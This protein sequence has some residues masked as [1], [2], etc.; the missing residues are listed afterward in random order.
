MW[1]NW[2]Q[3][4]LFLQRPHNK[5]MVDKKFDFLDKVRKLNRPTKGQFAW[6]ALGLAAALALFFFSRGFV[7]CWRLTALGG[8]SPSSCPGQMTVPLTTTN[9]AGTAVTIGTGV[10]AF[11]GPQVALPPPWDGASRV[12]I[13]IV[14]LDFGDW[15]ADRNGPSRSDTMI[16]LTIDPASKTAGMLSVPRDM[17]VNI[18]G[19]GYSKINNAYAFGEGYKLPGG[20][21]GLA[22]KTVENFLGINIQYYA[23]V[24]FTTFEKMVDTIGGVCLTIPEEI[25]V[26][27]TFEHSVTLKPGYQCL[28]GKSTLGYARNRY[29]TNG[30]VDRAGRQQQVI[31]AI[32]DK[33]FQPA[34]FL[35]LISQ[36]PTLYN[37]LS[38][39]I[40]TNLP[41]SDAMRLAVLAKDIPL[42]SIKQ[43][44]INYTMMQDGF[45]NVNGQQ[46]AILR[47]Y[48]DK[49]RELVDSIFGSGTMQ[50]LA[51]GTIE[52]KMKAEAARVV[53]INGTG[54]SGMAS[55]TSDYLKTQGMNI[56]GFGNTGDY[57]D[58]YN[59]P[60]P[61]RTTLIVHAG[62]PY[63]MQYLMALMKIKSLD[64]I[65]VDFNQ[66]SPA[67]IIVALGSDWGSNNPM[68]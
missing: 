39:G 10:P 33:V 52:E 57:P 36:A 62:K 19:F 34:N 46:L 61:T 25:T 54:V 35:S 50:P 9:P 31:L 2:L 22:V 5:F 4:E 49:I 42:A 21:P 45:T 8:I 32:R 14:G 7:A 3:M 67:D 44:V 65:K 23:Q 59:P 56:T 37:E 16:L 64:Q 38:G 68:P 6:L 28:D 66:N 12:T 40:N 58:S 17:W 20:G 30:D 48:P 55:K 13:L 24:E 11:T 18:P 47:P 60:F 26:G 1:V 53:V 63:A 41:L 15:S 27:R 51:A 43:G 29:T